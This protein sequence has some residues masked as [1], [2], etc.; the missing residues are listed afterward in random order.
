VVGVA[1]MVVTLPLFALPAVLR[2]GPAAAKFQIGLMDVLI[3]LAVTAVLVIA[4]EGIHAA[5][6]FLFGAR[7]RFGTILVGRVMPAVYTTSEGHRFSR[8][9]Y[10]AVAAAP[11]VVIS[12]LGFWACFGTWAGF[13]ILPLAFHFGG[14]VGDRFA[15]WRVL[16]EPP[17]TECEDLRD[18]IR[19]HRLPV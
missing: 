17:G 5:V 19:F 6:M 9:Q 18:G 7:P 11:A 2:G 12:V 15:I 1:A 14:C 13:L 8:G 10:L 16:C 3:V 4:H